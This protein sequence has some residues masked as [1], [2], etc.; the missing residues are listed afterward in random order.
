MLLALEVQ[1]HVENSI[2]LNYGLLNHVLLALEVQR[3]LENSICLNYGL[4]NHKQEKILCVPCSGGATP[5]GH[6][7]C[8]NVFIT[9]K[10]ASFNIDHTWVH[11]EGFY[12]T[13]TTFITRTGGC[14]WNCQ[15]KKSFGVILG[16]VACNYDTQ[17]GGTF[18]SRSSKRPISIANL[19][20]QSGGQ[21]FNT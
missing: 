13:E 3:Y 17:I 21:H 4:L 11:F 8:F 18:L 16:Q 15:G 6:F 7:P 2:F 1:R 19:H 20:V 9:Q 12:T 10:D 5:L 14:S